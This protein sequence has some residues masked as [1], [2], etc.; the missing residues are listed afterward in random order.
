[1]S[2]L[3][4]L[5]PIKVKIVR[6][7]DGKHQYPAFNALAP[8]LR[9][10]M[11]WAEFLDAHGIGWHYDKCSGFG[12]SDAVNPQVAPDD[13]HRNDDPSCWFGAT[14]VPEPFAQAAAARFPALVTI[15]SE[16]S[17]ERFYD[18]RAHLHEETEILDL[19]DLQKLQARLA[20]EAMPNAPTKSP[21]ETILK[22]RE[23]M[24]DPDHPRRGIRKNPRRRWA[25][26]KATK[27]LTVHPSQR[28][29]EPPA[30]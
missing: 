2:D 18:G 25:D 4:N 27:R 24:L 21:S 3:Q 6:G 22:L 13:E 16:E 5:V 15:I 26:W 19:Q 7:P 8:D 17:F 29:P 23:E 20:L 12:E 1:M 14:C 10:H 28:K 30:Q 11:D 9:A